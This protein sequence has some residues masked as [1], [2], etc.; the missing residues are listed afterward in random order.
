MNDLVVHKAA[1]P[2]MTDD[3]IAKVYALEE[4]LAQLPQEVFENHH[5][6]HGGMYARTVLLKAGVTATGALIQVPTVLIV[7]G[8]ATVYIDGEPHDLQGTTSCRLRHIA[9]RPCTRTSIP[10]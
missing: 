3:A 9:N 4:E 1:I 5:V 7:C 8:H 6:L 2:A 10:W